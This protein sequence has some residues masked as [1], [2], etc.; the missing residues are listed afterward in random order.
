MRSVYILLVTCFLSI[1]ITSF[2]IKK[3]KAKLLKKGVFTYNPCAGVKKTFNKI[4][5]LGRL[6]IKESKNKEK[7][8]SWVTKKLGKK[9]CSDVQDYNL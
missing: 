2:G 4:N 9:I 6:H 7:F 5:V 8:Q 1:S 3:K